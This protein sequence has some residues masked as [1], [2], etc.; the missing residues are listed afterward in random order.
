MLYLL[1]HVMPYYGMY[2]NIVCSSVYFPCPDGG[3]LR[4]RRRYGMMNMRI[5]KVI[6]TISYYSIVYYVS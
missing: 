6:I 2:Y 5:S 1:Y 4:S 3:P